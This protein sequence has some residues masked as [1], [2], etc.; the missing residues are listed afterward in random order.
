MAVVVFLRDGVIKT[1]A[2]LLHNEDFSTN[3]GLVNTALVLPG[4]YGVKWNLKQYS[5]KIRSSSKFRR[6]IHFSGWS[7]YR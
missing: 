6:H 5:K 1:H 4:M 3:K 2:S 7:F